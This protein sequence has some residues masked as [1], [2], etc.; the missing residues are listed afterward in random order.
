M[1]LTTQECFPYFFVST[2]R[3]ILRFEQN[4]SLIRRRLLPASKTVQVIPNMHFHT[5]LINISNQH[6]YITKPILLGQFRYILRRNADQ[7]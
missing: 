3:D 7:N 5:V 6:Y 2:A 4:L 1:I